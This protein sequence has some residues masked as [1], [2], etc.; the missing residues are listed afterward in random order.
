MFPVVKA[1]SVV[2]YDGY[3]AYKPKINEAESFIIFSFAG[4]NYRAQSIILKR[5]RRSANNGI[6]LSAQRRSTE[7]PVV[8]EVD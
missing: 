4:Y 7:S 8:I 5:R 1:N 6:G 2:E 3:L